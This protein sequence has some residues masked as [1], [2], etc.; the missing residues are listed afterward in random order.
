M[1]GLYW[2]NDVIIKCTILNLWDI[3]ENFTFMKQFSHFHLN[4]V[5]YIFKRKFKSDNHS[6]ELL[7]NQ[8]KKMKIA[9]EVKNDS[10]L[11]IFNMNPGIDPGEAFFFAKLKENENTY[12]LTGDKIALQSLNS[13]TFD[14]RYLEGRILLWEQILF[15]I[16]QSLSMEEIDKLFGNKEWN[17]SLL[18]VVFSRENLTNQKMLCT[19]LENYIKDSRDT[20]GKFLVENPKLKIGFGRNNEQ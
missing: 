15:E 5:L 10:L 16:V 17:D 19:T 13:L 11:N 6:L 1:K 8:L 4:S 3:L 7:S 14:I 9:E 2:D 20:F 12:F 18:K